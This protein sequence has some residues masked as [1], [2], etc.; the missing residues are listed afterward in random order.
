MAAGASGAASAVPEIVLRENYLLRLAKV[1]HGRVK[2][3][4]GLALITA[5]NQLS[6]VELRPGEVFTVPN[7]G[8]IL[9]EAIGACRLRI[10]PP[11]SVKQRL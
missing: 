3:V 6:D 11:L 7:Q 5:Y 2:C 1:K 8:L 9:I 10:E 4:S